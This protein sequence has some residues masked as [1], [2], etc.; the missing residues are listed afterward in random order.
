MI[1]SVLSSHSVTV[2]AREWL[3]E[4]VFLLTCC[5]P[6]NFQHQAGQYVSIFHGGEEREYTL[7]SPPEASQLQFLIKRIEGGKLSGFLADCA[8]GTVLA[9]SRAKGYLTYRP[10][11]RPVFFVA[12]GVGIA[13]FV[14]MVAAGVTG[15]T[16]IHGARTVSGLFYR[17]ELIAAAKRYISCV[18]GKLDV[19][20]VLPN[21]HR[22][23]VTEYANRHLQP[24]LYDFYLCGSRAMITDM[25]L[26]VDQRCPDARIYS[27]AYS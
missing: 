13:P 16:L 2:A 26:L 5:C 25:T 6:P 10:P 12:T 14:A 22:G 9:I 4:E 7:L 11:D 27:E 8:L 18:S 15:F 19:E 21:L 3:N 20:T 23:Y 17:S 24:G 1:D